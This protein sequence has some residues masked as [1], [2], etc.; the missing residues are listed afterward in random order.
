[1]NLGVFCSFRS[2]LISLASELLEI[3]PRCQAPSL[4][5]LR[6][7]VDDPIP[8]LGGDFLPKHQFEPEFA[9]SR[10]LQSG[11]VCEIHIGYELNSDRV[12]LPPFAEWI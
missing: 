3:L 2:L 4:I 7:F 5:S 11:P 10:R 8:D 6:A 12:K 9:E 1:M